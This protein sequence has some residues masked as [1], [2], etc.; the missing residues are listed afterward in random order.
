MMCCGH[1]L[2]KYPQNY[3]FLFVLTA[4]MGVLVG[5]TSAM[6]T[7]QSVVLAA[8][9]TV[10][11]FI[12]MTVYAWTTTTDF[13]GAG[14]Y[15]FAVLVCLMLFGLAISILDFYNVHIQWPM[16]FYDLCGVL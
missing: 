10:A 8:G 5:F 13:T 7:W 15:L 6:Y 16:I 2:R 4:C 1:I 3:V 12:G 11:I 9:I 14:P